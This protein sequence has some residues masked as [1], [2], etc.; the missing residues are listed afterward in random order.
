VVFTPLGSGRACITS[1]LHDMW[2]A[3]F[4]PLSNAGTMARTRCH[5]FGSGVQTMTVSA[6]LGFIGCGTLVLHIAS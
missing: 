3:D 5:R 2:M 6:R 1:D 4:W